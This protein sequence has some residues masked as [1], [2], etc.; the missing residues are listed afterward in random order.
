MTGF[1]MW[2]VTPGCPM[3]ACS[4]SNKC[5]THSP[6]DETGKDRS[7]AASRTVLALDFD[8]ICLACG[9]RRPAHGS[10]AQATWT[11]QHL[12]ACQRCRGPLCVERADLGAISSPQTVRP[13]RFGRVG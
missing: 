12:G 2:C 5:F 8:V 6:A 10:E 1:G 11:R 9:N 13:V 7:G 3:R 4:R